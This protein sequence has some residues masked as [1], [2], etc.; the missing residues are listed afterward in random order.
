MI[1]PSANPPLF[2][3]A[4]AFVATWLSLAM[5]VMVCAHLALDRRL[6]T[7][8]SLAHLLGS[9]S[10]TA[11]TWTALRYVILPGLVVALV[12]AVMVYRHVLSRISRAVL[13]FAFMAGWMLTAWLT[14]RDFVYDRE[15]P[16]VAVNGFLDLFM[17]SPLAW[18]LLLLGLVISLRSV[19][20]TQTR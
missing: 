10:G 3:A 1:R 17:T 12:A 8:W 16:L 6:A 9:P 11:A 14:S 13:A 19:S 4:L 20:R 5:T 2:E 7:Q 15:Q 18:P